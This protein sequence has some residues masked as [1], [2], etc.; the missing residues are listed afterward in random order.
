MVSQESAA[1]SYRR[2]VDRPRRLHMP[3]FSMSGRAFAPIK[4]AQSLLVFLFTVAGEILPRP[5]L[6]E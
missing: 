5:R 2:N 4:A 3:R 6:K 1:Q